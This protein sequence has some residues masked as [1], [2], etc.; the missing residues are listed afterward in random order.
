M[1]KTLN[2]SDFI[3][4]QPATMSATDV[5]ARGKAEGTEVSRSLV[6]MV[7]TRSSGKA[8]KGAA[9]TPPSKPTAA[10]M[11]S[12]ASKPD[13]T[14]LTAASGKPPKSKADFVRAYSSLSPKEVVEKGKAE[15]VTFDAR[16]VYRVRAMDKAARKRK[17]AAAKT[18][19]SPA[20]AANGAAPSVTPAAKPSSSAEDLLRA[21]AAELGLGRAAGI[22]EG[23]R[24][25]VRAV[26][27]G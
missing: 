1:P 9:K 27:R 19:T 21:L 16:Y 24:A 11:T 14:R 13:A 25:R 2:K 10:P 5:I 12:A 17:R 8:K 26:L 3:R 7:R 15:G 18:A 20:T 23:E 6:H 22:L 4:A